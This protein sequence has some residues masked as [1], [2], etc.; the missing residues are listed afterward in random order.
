MDVLKSIGDLEYE[1][2]MHKH[3]L[4]HE[5]ED[6]N[7]IDAFR[8]IDYNGNGSVTADELT[9]FISENLTQDVDHDA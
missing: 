9:K 3:K 2:E 4:V 8:L 1:I 5:C 7:T 6:F